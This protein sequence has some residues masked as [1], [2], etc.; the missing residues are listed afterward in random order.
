[1]EHTPWLSIL[2]F[3]PLLFGIL[4][5]FFK[6][7]ST[8]VRGLA[9]T[10]TIITFLISL[11]VWGQYGGAAHVNGFALTEQYSWISMVHVNYMLG[12]DGISLLMVLMTTVIWP[13]IVWV[14]QRDIKEREHQYYFW[15]LLLETAVLGVFLSLDLVLYYVFWEAML[16]P[17]Y[18]IVGIWGGPQRVYATVKFFLY[19]MVGSMVMLVSILALY[20]AA[21]ASTFDLPALQQ[22]LA[23]HGLGAAKEMLLFFGFFLAFAIKAPMWPFHTWVPDAYSQAPTGGTIMLVALKMGLYGFI[24]FCLPLFPHAVHDSAPV[25]ITFSV[26]GVIY[27][28]WVAAMQTDLKRLL[29]YSSISHVGVIML[30]IFALNGIGIAGAVIQMV[31][32]TLTMG[33]LFILVYGLYERRGSYAIADFGGLTKVMPAFTVVFLIAVLSSVA[34]PT[35]AGF[36]GEFMMLIGAFQTYPVATG[37]ATTAAIWSVVYMLWMFQRVMYGKIDKP[38][39]EKLPDWAMNEKIALV[40]LILLIFFIGVYPRPVLNPLNQSVSTIVGALPSDVTDTSAS[41][42]GYLYDAV[43]KNTGRLGEAKGG[44]Q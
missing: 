21:G 5:L 37:F 20:F 24:R 38:E 27:A 9:L 4:V 14:S 8:V 29:A 35:T 30:A 22:N 16:I 33:A 17:L 13:F 36:T 25:I 40:P 15:A 41:S 3:V 18:F 19:T 39:N 43:A 10:G 44:A 1:M 23:M 7:N 42:G 2:T 34:L 32:H 26:I 12:L 28:A 6:D 11:M 31:A